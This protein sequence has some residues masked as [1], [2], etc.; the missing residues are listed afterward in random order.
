M[1]PSS[2]TLIISWALISSFEAN[3]AVC[4]NEEIISMHSTLFCS[5]VFFNHNFSL[6]VNSHFLLYTLQGYKGITC[7]IVDRD[8][9]GFTINK[10]EDK[11]GIVASGTCMLT[12]ED[13]KVPATNVLGEVGQG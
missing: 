6:M 11:L 12:L 4:K 9:P 1:T 5:F 8:T 2:T 13:V 7:F 3:I 10:P